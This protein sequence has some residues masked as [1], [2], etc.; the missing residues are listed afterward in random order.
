MVFPLTQ[1]TDSFPV[2]QNKS[3]IVEAKKEECTLK[4]KKGNLFQNL[5]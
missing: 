2:I 5:H 1:M 3:L 4:E